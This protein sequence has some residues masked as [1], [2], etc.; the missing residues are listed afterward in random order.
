MIDKSEFDS[1]RKKLEQSDKY[2]EEAIQKSREIIRLSKQIIYS[3]HRGD[4]TAA[5]DLMKKIKMDKSILLQKHFDS[6]TD[7]PNVAMQEY[8]EAAS[9]FDFV[10]KGVIPDRKE[11]N[12]TVEAYLGGLADL[13]GEL[14]RKAIDD[15]INNKIEDAVKIKDLVDE[16]YGGFL[17]LDLRNGELRKKSDSIKWS[18]NKLQ[19]VIFE[20][21]LKRR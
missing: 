18:L 3:L 14:V 21:K 9:Y 2:R 6:D 13:T 12:V 8:V 1:V 20:A 17:K 19:E 15:L 7:M 5:K 4:I 10:I 11:L 16:I